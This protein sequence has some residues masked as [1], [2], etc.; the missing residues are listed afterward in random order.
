MILVQ[1][2]ALVG[3]RTLELE[4][5]TLTDPEYSEQALYTRTVRLK[6]LSLFGRHVR[7]SLYIL[8]GL[9]GWEMR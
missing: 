6:G 1:T 9:L 2:A 7:H 4:Q 5:F 3:A 8:R